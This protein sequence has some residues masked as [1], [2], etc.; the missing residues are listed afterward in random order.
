MP[1]LVKGVAVLDDRNPADQWLFIV[2]VAED[3]AKS[4]PFIGRIAVRPRGTPHP[5]D[6]PSWEFDVQGN[7]LHVTPSVRTSTTVPIEGS[8]ENRV[9]ELFHNSGDWHVAFVRWS[10]VP[11][12]D[13]MDAGRNSY[14]HR[15]NAHILSPAHQGMPGQ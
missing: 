10:Q 9:V 4:K 5:P 12:E 11:E 15:I 6:R 3:P 1:D 8:K 2:E 13:R 14:C 7:L